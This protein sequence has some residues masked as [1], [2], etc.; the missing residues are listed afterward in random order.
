MKKSYL[1]LFLASFF[2]FNS[3]EKIKDVAD[4]SFDLTLKKE[5]QESFNGIGVQFQDVINLSI[6]DE[7]I[8][9]Y[10]DNLKKVKVK[11][12]YFKVKEFSGTTED[13]FVKIY[14]RETI[15]L[16]QQLNLKNLFQ[17]QTPVKIGSVQSLDK[18]SDQLLNNSSVSVNYLVKPVQSGTINAS[19]KLEVVAE[20][21][22]TAN[23]L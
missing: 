16:E 4:V 22:V 21:K 15:L 6:L 7:N 8:K 20:I 18:L 14:T 19:V 3:C 12:F 23:P 2:M 13:F 5:I 17:S 1:L 9:P 11:N 10:K